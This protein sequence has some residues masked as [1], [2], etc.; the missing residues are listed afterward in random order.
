MIGQIIK[1]PQV[2]DR[3]ND[4]R[5][6]IF[7]AGGITGCTNWQDYVGKRIIDALP[8]IVLDPRRENWNINSDHIDSVVQISWECKHLRKSDHILFWFPCTSDCPIALF[9]LGTYLEK[10]ISIS[11]G[12]DTRYNRRLD[13]EVQSLLVRP[14]IPIWHDLDKMIDKLIKNWDQTMLDQT[15]TLVTLIPESPKIL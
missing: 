5:K 8:I 7:L 1:S 11:V 13:V 6:S 9:E 10:N 4:D 3:A 12:T 15:K 14:R 2:W